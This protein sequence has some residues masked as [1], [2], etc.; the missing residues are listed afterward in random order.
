MILKLKHN[1]AV[2]QK[3]LSKPCC[4]SPAIK[5]TVVAPVRSTTITLYDEDFKIV[6]VNFN[7]G[8]PVTVSEYVG[9]TIL[10]LHN[11]DGRFEVVT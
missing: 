11:T 5:Q 8:E 10:D 1:N 2:S 4:G 3:V 9:K 6:K 7:A